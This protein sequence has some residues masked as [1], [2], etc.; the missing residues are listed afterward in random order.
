MGRHQTLN[1]G[2]KRLGEDDCSN[3][4][5]NK[6]RDH[7]SNKSVQKESESESISSETEV[8]VSTK[9]PFDV[10]SDFKE[11]FLSELTHHNQVFTY[12][13]TQVPQL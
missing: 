1:F 4:E 2:I 6:S 12:E 8:Q 5:E 7:A 11:D 10:H 13:V 9:N 3:S